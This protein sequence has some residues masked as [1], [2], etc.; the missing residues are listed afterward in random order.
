[1]KSFVT[2]LAII[3]LVIVPLPVYA[4]CPGIEFTWDGSSSSA[5]S[6]T[7]NWTHTGDPNLYPGSAT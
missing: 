1:M 2:A 7:N 3:A 4:D 6:N 5:W